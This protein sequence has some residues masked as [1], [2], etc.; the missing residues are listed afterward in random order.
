MRGCKSRYWL[1]QQYNAWGM[2]RCVDGWIFETTSSPATAIKH[3]EKLNCKV[4]RI[5]DCDCVQFEKS[6]GVMF[7]Q[8]KIRLYIAVN[9][10]IDNIIC[11]W[12]EKVTLKSLMIEFIVNYL[13]CGGSISANNQD[14]HIQ[15]RDNF[16][17]ATLK[18]KSG[19][20]YVIK[21]QRLLARMAKDRIIKMGNLPPRNQCVY[22]LT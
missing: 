17:G 9:Q 5:E 12:V 11:S 2:K 15:F 6:D 20:E 14:F 22:T 8:R 19:N 7:Y 18:T 4:V 3:I 1:R 13:E 16:G 10:F 21:A